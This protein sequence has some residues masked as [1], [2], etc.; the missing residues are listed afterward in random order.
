MAYK[1]VKTAFDK[2]LAAYKRATQRE[3]AALLVEEDVTFFVVKHHGKS[4]MHWDHK[5]RPEALR[6]VCSQDRSLSLFR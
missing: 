1:D 5:N 4:H 2:A 3:F 6:H